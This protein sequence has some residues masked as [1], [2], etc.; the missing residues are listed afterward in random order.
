MLMRLL[1]K[2]QIVIT[3]GMGGVVGKGL[4]RCVISIS[5]CNRRAYIVGFAGLSK[6]ILIVFCRTYVWCV[7]VAC[8]VYRGVYI[9]TR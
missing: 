4:G 7:C 5:A 8:T 2:C 9:F 6:C 1:K 3:N